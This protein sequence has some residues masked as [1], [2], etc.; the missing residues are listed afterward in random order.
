MYATTTYRLDEL[1][2]VIENNA[3]SHSVPCR[4]VK[5]ILHLD[6]SD[7]LWINHDQSRSITIPKYATLIPIFAVHWWWNGKIYTG[8]GILHLNM[9][10]TWLAVKMYFKGVCFRFLKTPRS[11]WMRAYTNKHCGY[12]PGLQIDTNAQWLHR[13]FIQQQWSVC[14]I[15]G[16]VSLALE[17]QYELKYVLGFFW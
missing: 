2:F 7:W 1:R 15:G 12:H 5:L 9:T 4:A 13:I 8:S 3:F 10:R 11:G 14:C 17:G 16:F 6:F